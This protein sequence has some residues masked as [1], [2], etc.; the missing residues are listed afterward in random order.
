L[1]ALRRRIEAA[2]AVRFAQAIENG[3]TPQGSG[4]LRGH[5]PLQD[6]IARFSA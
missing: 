6:V 4:A 5:V 2:P 3:E 1:A